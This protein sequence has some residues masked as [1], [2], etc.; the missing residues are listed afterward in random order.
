MSKGFSLDVERCS[1]CYACVVACFDQNDLEVRDAKGAWRQVFTV[2]DGAFPEA[3][4]SYV[5]L[6]CQHCA[7]A[8]CIAVCPS[9]ALGRSAGGDAVVVEA[10]LCIGCRMC[11]LACP[12]G[13]PRYGA[14]GRMRKCDLCGA[15]VEA[16]LEPACVRACPT[17][18]LK[19]GEDAELGRQAGQR[20]ARRLARP[21]T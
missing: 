7:S 6:A 4:L 5:S 9:G 2:E 21:Q 13:V 19:F 14:D 12:F 1:G 3:R 8:P 10:S 17:R 16:G 20:A 11:A 18:A 15:R